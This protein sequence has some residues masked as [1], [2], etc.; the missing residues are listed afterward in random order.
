MTENWRFEGNAEDSVGSVDGVASDVM[1]YVGE[2]VEEESSLAFSG[3][4]CVS[5]DDASSLQDGFSEY[6]CYG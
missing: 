6:E 3:T 2:K 5:M 4:S 1:T